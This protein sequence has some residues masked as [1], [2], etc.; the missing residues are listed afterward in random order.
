ML[1]FY[2]SDRYLLGMGA[3]LALLAVSFWWGLK[4][5]RRWKGSPARLRWI[6][7]G[8]SLWFVL[9]SLTL[10]ELGFALFYDRTDSFNITNV[11]DRWLKRHVR[12]NPQGYRDT[13][14]FT[15]TIPEGRKRIVFLGDSFT[16]GHGLE[17]E[18]DR[19]SNRVRQEL[20]N[21]AKGRFTVA[22]M[23]VPGIAINDMVPM[24]EH[25]VI[26][27]DCRVDV[28]VYTICLN[29]IEWMARKQTEKQ[30]EPLAKLKPQF[31]LLRNTYFYNWLYYRLQIWR[32]PRLKNYYEF[33]REYY[34]GPPWLKMREQLDNLHKVLR[35]QGT[36]LR[37]VVFPFL[38]N[39]GPDYPFR[40][41]HQRIVGYAK[42][43]RIPVLDLEPVLTPHASDGLMV[44]PFDA[45]P[46]SRANELAADAIVKDL[47][48]DLIHPLDENQ[49]KL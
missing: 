26:Q 19:F 27:A 44:N 33:V 8:L 13:N 35:E 45:H 1:L 29:D 2:L 49:R 15:R 3:W 32:Q 4:S 11:S 12:L 14:P 43:N 9:C 28:V 34:A 5:R 24:W 37:L 6:H 39:L 31:F 47:L 48:P 40:E 38:H 41:A 17:R 10:P 42:E 25:S 7:A 20:E 22:N 23:G 46:N 21:V 16:F 30:Y 18:A 36:E